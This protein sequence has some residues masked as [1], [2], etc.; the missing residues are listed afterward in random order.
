MG[1]SHSIGMRETSCQVE[2]E[3]T[4]TRRNKMNSAFTTEDEVVLKYLE[5]CRG[6]ADR[7]LFLMRVAESVQET[8]EADDDGDLADWTAPTRPPSPSTLPH[9]P[10]TLGEVGVLD[11]EVT[12]DPQAGLYIFA[13]P[14]F[15]LLNHSLF[16]TVVWFILRT[17]APEKEK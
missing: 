5:A 17:M 12:R 2:N 1:K 14:L 4:Y 8:L 15:Y 3:P 10:L 13:S 11:F 9:K 6:M 16:Q 7:R